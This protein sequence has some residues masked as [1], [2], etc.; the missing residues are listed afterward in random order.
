MSLATPS[1]ASGEIPIAEDGYTMVQYT[2][3][4]K[5]YFE[6]LM[7]EP[8]DARV[9]HEAAWYPEAREIVIK[10]IELSLWG[11][12]PEPLMMIRPG[13]RLVQPETA[14]NEPLLYYATALASIAVYGDRAPR[15]ILDQF[16]TAIRL[17]EDQDYPQYLLAM[18]RRRHAYYL[19]LRR[20]DAKAR[21]EEEAAVADYLEAVP[22]LPTD[23]E[24]QRMIY[25]EL[26][27]PISEHLPIDLADRLRDGLLADKRVDRCLA[28]TLSGALEIRLAWDSR[29]DRWGSEVSPEQWDGFE[30]HLTIARTALMEAWKID[31]RR[32]EAAENMIAVTMGGHGAPGLSAR[33]WFDRAVAAQFDWER[34]YDKYAYSI[35]PRWGGSWEQ[36]LDFAFECAATRRYDTVVPAK[37][38]E[39]AERIAADMHAANTGQEPWPFWLSSEVNAT[40]WEV[41]E[42]LVAAHPDPKLVKSVRVKMLIIA[43]LGGQYER[44]R[45]LLLEKVEWDDAIGKSF[46]AH[47]DQVVRECAAF[48]GPLGEQFLAAEGHAKAGRWDDAAAAYAQLI[49]MSE[50]Y[51]QETNDVLR[52]QRRGEV[53]V[54]LP[55]SLEQIARQQLLLAMTQEKIARMM[56]VF[57]QG[58]WTDIAITTDRALDVWRLNGGLASGATKRGPRLSVT[59]PSQLQLLTPLGQCYEMQGAIDFSDITE[60]GG[61]IVYLYLRYHPDRQHMRADEIMFVGDADRV[62]IEVG[63]VAAPP[64]PG[65]GGVGPTGAEQAIEVPASRAGM[66]AFRVPMEAQVRFHVQLWYGWVS[67]RVNDEL[68]AVRRLDEDVKTSKFGQYFGLGTRYSARKGNVY[69]EHLRMRRL[70]STQPPPEIAAGMRQEAVDRIRSSGSGR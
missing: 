10:L 32:P 27:I 9:D 41:A 4:R 3:A 16:A 33:D 44:A 45:T 14:P 69:V 54:T 46:C 29:G 66:A 7:L 17:A 21:A 64:R 57:S 8:F 53:P 47:K 25:S 22:Q 1:A 61:A 12:D 43:W 51:V 18:M 60:A 36:M 35:Y 55:D 23:W 70:D 42:R 31:P 19:H 65:A 50:T 2:A 48:G 11:K 59:S 28:L 24:T 15:T 67:L 37:F 6:S 56:A 63:T 34:A 26:R 13:E 62:E 58:E 49:A 39:V 68:I 30:K 52:R 40:F 5:K 38:I 20:E